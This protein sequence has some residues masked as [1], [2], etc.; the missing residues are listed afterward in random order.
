MSYRRL[1]QNRS[2][3]GT[4]CQHT[5]SNHYRDAKTGE[6]GACLGPACD[7]PGFLWRPSMFPPPFACALLLAACTTWWSTGSIVREPCLHV[8][9]RAHADAVDEWV[10]TAQASFDVPCA[11]RPDA[12]ASAR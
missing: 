2:R 9:V 5:A 4:P 1:C 8:G 3:S 7:C 12:S 11:E 6:G 10:A